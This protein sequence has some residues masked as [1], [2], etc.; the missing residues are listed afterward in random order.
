M[1]DCVYSPAFLVQHLVTQHAFDSKFWVFLNWIIFHVFITA[2]AVDEFG[3]TAGIVS[4]H[5]LIEPI[6]GDIADDAADQPPEAR[7]LGPGRW[8]VPGDFPADRLMR[9]LLGQ[10]K[11][12]TTAGT[13]GGLITRR[14]GRAAATGDVVNIANV[15]L[16]VHHTDDAGTIETAIVSLEEPST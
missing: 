16:E 9:A 13:V 11:P 3:G 4:L 14:L 8:I 5:D 2:I 10:A 6:V 1:L 7:P 12:I 15:T